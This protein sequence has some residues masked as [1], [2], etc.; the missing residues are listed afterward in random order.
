MLTMNLVFIKA[1]PED[2]SGF[3]YWEDDFE[4]MDWSELLSHGSCADMFLPFLGL[5]LF[6]WTGG[7]HWGN[8]F[9]VR[10]LMCR[11]SSAPQGNLTKNLCGDRLPE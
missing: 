1:E 2:I 9:Y 7:E 8:R 11:A 10:T 4:D 5:P 3:Y 6:P